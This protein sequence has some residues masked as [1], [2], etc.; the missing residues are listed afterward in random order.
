MRHA[1]TLLMGHF[2]TRAPQQSDA[3]GISA[4]RVPAA[5]TNS[6]GQ[7]SV[8]KPGLAKAVRKEGE[9]LGPFKRR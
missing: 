1:A 6:G 9:I 5:D 4:W 2:P 7:E 3:A 8:R